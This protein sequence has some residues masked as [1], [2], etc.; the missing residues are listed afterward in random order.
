MMTSKTKRH[1]EKRWLAEKPGDAGG[2]CRNSPGLAAVKGMAWRRRKKSWRKR[3]GWR[4]AKRRKLPACLQGMHRYGGV[5]NQSGINRQ[6]SVVMA[7]H[8]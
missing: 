8:P 5:S 4:S 6:I 1:R 7:A 2:N 3:R